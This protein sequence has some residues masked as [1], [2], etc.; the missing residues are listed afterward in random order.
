MFKNKILPK[1]LKVWFAGYVKR[2]YSEDAQYNLNIKMKEEHARR[3]CSEIVDIGKSLELDKDI[4]CLAEIAALFHD[5]GRFEQYTRY[6]TFVD[7]I[8]E[9]HAALGVRIINKE[10]ILDGFDSKKRSTILR[11]ITYH[12][13]AELPMNETGK[14]ILLTKLL[15]DA[16]K[17]DIWRI[18]TGYY[19]KKDGIRN[20]S[21]E[22]DLPDTPEVSD[23]YYD[24]Y[25]SRKNC[26][27]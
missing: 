17:I 13:H 23:K 4:L 6:G 12:N 8:S 26:Q 5:I 14:C 11:T 10:G 16:D 9:D 24:R 15:R 3:V 27:N 20:I 21:I 25:C 2:F 7:G 18:V 19:H 1:Q 22:L